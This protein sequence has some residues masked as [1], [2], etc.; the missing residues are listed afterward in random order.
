LLLCVTRHLISLGSN[1]SDNWASIAARSS[2]VMTF[3]PHMECVISKRKKG[4]A[5]SALLDALHETTD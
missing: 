5:M 3:S 4:A 1:G 2:A